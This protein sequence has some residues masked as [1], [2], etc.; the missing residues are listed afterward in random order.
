M[1]SIKVEPKRYRKPTTNGLK[2]G[3]SENTTL[4]KYRNPFVRVRPSKN[5]KVVEY[6]Q[7]FRC[8]II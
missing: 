7:S 8:L 3:K 2:E 5:R 4:K 6:N 1:M